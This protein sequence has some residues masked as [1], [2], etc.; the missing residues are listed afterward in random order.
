MVVV[1]VAVFTGMPLSCSLYFSSDMKLVFRLLPY[2]RCAM[3][4]AG[5]YVIVALA[6]D[7]PTCAITREASP[8]CYPP[9]LKLQGQAVIQAF[10]GFTNTL[11][12]S[13]GNEVNHFTPVGKGDEWNAPCQKK[14]L[15]D[16]RVYMESVCGSG[17]TTAN[18]TTRTT[19]TRR[20][21]R[22]IPIGLVSADDERQALATYYNCQDDTNDPYQRAEWYG[23]NAYVF[24]DGTAENYS[25]ALGFQLLDQSFASFNYSIPVLLTEFGCLSDTFAT[26]QEYEGQRNFYQAQWML[27][28]SSTLRQHFAGGFAFEYS[29]ERENAFHDSPY[30]FTKMGKQNYGIGFLEPED[31][32]DVNISCSYHPLPS[33]YALQRAYQIGQDSMQLT[34]LDD[35][36]LEEHRRQPS[37]C[38]P[39]YPSLGEFDWSVVDA[40]P[41]LPCPRHSHMRWHSNPD[42]CAG[43]SQHKGP[44]FHRSSHHNKD[45]S[46]KSWLSIATGLL[47][48]GIVVVLL[49]VAV[50][51]GRRRLLVGH[52]WNAASPST[53]PYY[54]NYLWGKTNS[55]NG[56][57]SSSSSMGDNDEDERT[58]LLLEQPSQPQPDYSSVQK[59]TS[60]Y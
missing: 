52:E 11:A 25:Q 50:V 7:C 26:V 18:A 5:I 15:R 16:M 29:I 13:A 22:S 55:S 49:L 40:V 4:A 32:N 19:T 17:P 38:P 36:E 27:D 59:H 28:Q 33:Y 20:G 14:F 21:M 42:V 24:C 10:A 43:S 60:V 12:F 39:H 41:D 23:L 6:H 31:C 53:Q 48:V 1:A 51:V 46:G 56:S 45:D 2:I 35:F 54:Y 44:G 57:S 9:E 34:T 30:P 3:E 47:I 8:D 58:G 37:K